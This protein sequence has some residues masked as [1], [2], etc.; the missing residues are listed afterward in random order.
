MFRTRV[1]KAIRNNNP[2]M[3]KRIFE[4]V[5]V[6]TRN[7]ASKN[8]IHPSFHAG[9]LVM[10][11]SNE[12]LEKFRKNLILV[13]LTT[14]FFNTHRNHNHQIIFFTPNP[15]EAPSSV[16]QFHP[17]YLRCHKGAFIN[18]ITQ[19]GGPGCHFGDAL[20]EVVSKHQLLCDRGGGGKNL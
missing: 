20:Y 7:P 14:D 9:Y 8:S 17:R 5:F 12:L 1:T 13:F 19:V 4:V 18:D 11:V 10:R 2:N 6:T 3:T 15:S 16:T